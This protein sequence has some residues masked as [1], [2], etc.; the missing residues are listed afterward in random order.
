[1]VIIYYNARKLKIIYLTSI[2][3]HN[4]AFIFVFMFAKPKRKIENFPFKEIILF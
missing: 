2:V 3:L 4:V 1:M